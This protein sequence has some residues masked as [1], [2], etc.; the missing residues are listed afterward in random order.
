LFASAADIR[1]TSTGMTVK[2]LFAKDICVR[3]EVQVKLLACGLAKAWQ[4]LGKGQRAEF[5]NL[6]TV[7]ASATLSF[8]V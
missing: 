1:Q 4:R 8:P 2:T 3:A 5:R 6:R 7:A